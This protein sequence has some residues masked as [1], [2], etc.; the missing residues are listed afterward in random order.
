MPAV[1][2][3]H[4]PPDLTM[5]AAGRLYL[6]GGNHRVGETFSMGAIADGKRDIF[7]KN[8]T[9]RRAWC[10][11]HDVSYSQWVFPDP[12]V[13]DGS[14]LQGKVAS[15]VLS[16]YPGGLPNDVF[17]PISELN[18]F[19]DR[20]NATDTHYSPLGN[21]YVARKIAL[22]TLGAPADIDLVPFIAAGKTNPVY[23]GD[24]G[25]KCDPKLTEARLAP[26]P[27][28]GISSAENGMASGNNGLIKIMESPNAISDRKLMIFGDSF[29]RLMLPELARY[30]KTIVFFRTPYFHFEMVKGVMPD[31]IICGMAERYF[32]SPMP[33]GNRPHFLAYPLTLGQS[34]TPEEAF[35]PMWKRLV[36][37][38]ALAAAGFAD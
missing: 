4:I 5:S 6:T 2:G 38:Q 33:D 1:T 19:P 11:R 22:Q 24:L 15:L 12:I 30:W 37:Q 9:F 8:Q 7:L 25:S 26:Q 27:V 32:A 20:Q 23:C 18:G 17:Y 28:A 14:A 3:R 29:L 21:M 34:L 36:D 31:D 16:T 13:F 10:Y 35:M